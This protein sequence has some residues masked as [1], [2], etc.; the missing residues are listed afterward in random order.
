MTYVFSF[1]LDLER[2]AAAAAVVVVVVVVVVAVAVVD[3]P[4]RWNPC[5][6]CDLGQTFEVGLQASAKNMQEKE[7]ERNLKFW[8]LFTVS[9]PDT[10]YADGIGPLFMVFVIDKRLK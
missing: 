8:L 10:R 9:W 2:S 4:C 7:E 1:T 5:G 6:G 3:T